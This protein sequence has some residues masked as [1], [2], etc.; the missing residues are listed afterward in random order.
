MKHKDMVRVLKDHGFVLIRNNKHEI[1]SNG[2]L[3]VAV[4]RS[5]EIKSHTVNV[6]FQQAHIDRKSI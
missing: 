6:I 4:P 3:T 2:V 1:F 5:K